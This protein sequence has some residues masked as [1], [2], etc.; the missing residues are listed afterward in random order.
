MDT[1]AKKNGNSYKYSKCTNVTH[2]FMASFF[3]LENDVVTTT[4]L[5]LHVFLYLHTDYMK[6]LQHRIKMFCQENNMESPVE[7]RLLDTMSELG[8]VA[9]ELLK[10]S[11]Y[12]RQP[13]EYRETLK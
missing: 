10:M 12:G 11:N 4:I 3:L 8:E 7:F 13:M 6:Q 1:S 2:G 5:M 9:K